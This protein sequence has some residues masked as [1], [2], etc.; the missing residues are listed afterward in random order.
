VGLP[1]FEATAGDEI[2]IDVILPN[3]FTAAANAARAAADAVALSFA[4]VSRR[5]FVA[6]PS[7]GA[8]GVDVPGSDGTA[9]TGG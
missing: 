1:F 8:V 6:L 3:A 4:N 7:T 2:V 9:I 5:T